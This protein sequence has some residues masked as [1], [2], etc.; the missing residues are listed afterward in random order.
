MKEP[1]EAWYKLLCQEEGE[2]YNTPIPK[3]GEVEDM[4]KKMQVSPRGPIPSRPV[5]PSNGKTA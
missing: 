4:K 3:E 1:Q 5:L 2:Y